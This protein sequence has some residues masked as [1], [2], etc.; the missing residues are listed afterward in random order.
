M[1]KKAAQ[2]EPIEIDPRCIYCKHNTGENKKFGYMWHCSQLG[3]CVPF[4]WH[5]C[6]AQSKGRGS[7]EVDKEKYKDFKINNK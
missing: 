5:K 2:S 7:F 3:Y 6:E 1:S 4:G